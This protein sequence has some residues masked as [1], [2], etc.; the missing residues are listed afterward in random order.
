MLGEKERL[1]E[2]S[3]LIGLGRLFK[4]NISLLIFDPGDWRGVDFAWSRGRETKKHAKAVMVLKGL[5]IVKKL[6]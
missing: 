4:R 2:E 3:G 5:H 1:V 6:R